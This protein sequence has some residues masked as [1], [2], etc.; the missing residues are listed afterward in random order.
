MIK[1][2]LSSVGICALSSTAAEAATTPKGF[3][4]DQVSLAKQKHNLSLMKQSLDKL[5]LIASQ[6]AD[7]ISAWIEYANLTHNKPLAL[8]KQQLLAKLPPIKTVYPSDIKAE[9]VKKLKSNYDS[10]TDKQ[11]YKKMLGVQQKII[12]LEQVD[13]W[14]RFRLANLLVINGQ[15]K[16][17]K[18]TFKQFFE[19]YPTEKHS[20]ESQYA[21]FLFLNGIDDYQTIITHSKFVAQ[22]LRTEKTQ[23]I[24]D[25][26]Q[27]TL[28]LI[29]LE[30]QA[31]D[32]RQHHDYS[33]LLEIQKQLVQLKPSDTWEAYALANTYAKLNQTQKGDEVFNQPQLIK[34][35]DYYQALTTYLLG[36]DRYQ[37]ILDLTSDLEP[38]YMTPKIQKIREQADS[39]LKFEQA[40]QLWEKQQPN[41]AIGLLKQLPYSVD[42]NEQLAQWYTERHFYNEAENQYNELMTHHELSLDQQINLLVLYQTKQQDFKIQNQTLNNVLS[43]PLTGYQKQKLLKILIVLNKSN[44]I[45]KLSRQI[46]VTEKSEVSNTMAMMKNDVAK[47]HRQHHEPQKALSEWRQAVFYSGLS[48]TLPVDDYTVY[49]RTDLKDDWLKKS[50][51]SSMTETHHQQDQTVTTGMHLSHYSGTEGYSSVDQATLFVAGAFPLAEGRAKIQYDWSDYNAGKMVK[52]NPSWGTCKTTNCEQTSQKQNISTLSFEWQ[53]EFLK[54]DIGQTPTIDHK[55]DLLGGV[56]LSNKFK[57][58]FSYTLQA[59]RRRLNNSLLSFYGQKD[60]H[61]KQNWGGVDV[62]QVGL[63]LSKSLTDSSGVWSYSDAGYLSG[64]NVVSNTRFRN[65]TGFYNHLIDEPNQ[66]FTL[67][68]NTGLTHYQRDLGDYTL[69]QGGYYSPQHAISIGMPIRWL[70]STDYYSFGA[71][72]YI[73]YSWSKHDAYARY[74]NKKITPL[75]L[76]DRNEKEHSGTSKGIS[77]A[78]KLLA[79]KRLSSHFS[80]GTLLNLEYQKDY[81]PSSAMVYLKYSKSGWNGGMNL[82]IQVPKIYSDQ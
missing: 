35:A 61:T 13:V 34:D 78:L 18:K 80:I 37:K 64:K 63:N 45:E 51:K 52:E 56:A 30:K 31:L 20:S 58:K 49:L 10:L 50:I 24:I 76:V 81:V 77:Y 42:R 73:G 66:R 25:H 46:D 16:Q 27:Q 43:Q 67:G 5:D 1:K 74:P 44:Y 60:Q 39:C 32:Y 47:W 72:S 6:D 70:K 26:A 28:K 40:K 17:A 22:E 79:E 14:E 12:T 29:A 53:D 23:K 15:K 33:R 65:F 9:Q 2:I 71:E 75:N 69:G 48:Q 36:T 82:P 8:Q 4:L 57:D 11:S 59:E 55:V 7:V 62:N 41:E 3:L 54:L 38:Q 19:R 68:I 21:Y